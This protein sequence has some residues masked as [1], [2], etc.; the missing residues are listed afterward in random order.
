M[1][2]RGE[3]AVGAVIVTAGGANVPRSR[4]EQLAQ[5]GRLVGP[6]GNRKMQQLVRA[7][8]SLSGISLEKLGECRFVPLIAARE[9]WPEHDSSKNG[10]RPVA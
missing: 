7:T 6:V 5:G 8:K 10:V 1:G 4:S 9:G 3:A 2:R